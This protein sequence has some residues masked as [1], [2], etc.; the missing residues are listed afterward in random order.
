ML[1]N[2]G[3][4]ADQRTQHSTSQSANHRRVGAGKTGERGYPDSIADVEFSL[5]DQVML[6]E[7]DCLRVAHNLE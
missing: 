3:V 7:D 6:P 4:D 5:V 1:L 2:G